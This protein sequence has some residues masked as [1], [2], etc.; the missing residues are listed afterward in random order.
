MERHELVR[1]AGGI[2]DIDGSVGERQGGPIVF[3]VWIKSYG[4]PAI[5]CA[6][7]RPR[8]GYWP[9]VSF[10]PCGDIQGVKTVHVGAVFVGISFHVNRLSAGID[11]GRARATENWAYVATVRVARSVHRKK[12]GGKRSSTC[13]RAVWRGY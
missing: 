1:A 12:A 4:R 10:R 13:R 7:D 11:N 6:R 5:G 8:D 3:G 9:K 2:G